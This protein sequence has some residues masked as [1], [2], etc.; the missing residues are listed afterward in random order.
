MQALLESK[1]MS[2][3]HVRGSLGSPRSYEPLDQPHTACKQSLLQLPGATGVVCT[4][5]CVPHP[6]NSWAGW[7]SFG[8]PKEFQFLEFQKEFQAPTSGLRVF[9]HPRENV[10]FAYSP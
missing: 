9:F 8:I 10:G 5:Q 4:P 2:M 6:W 3:V 1:C 7:Y